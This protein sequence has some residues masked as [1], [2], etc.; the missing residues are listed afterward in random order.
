MANYALCTDKRC[1]IKGIC[2]RSTTNATV[3]KGQEYIK[4]NS[5]TYK[6]AYSLFFPITLD[7]A[8]AMGMVA[9]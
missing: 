7:S 9:P 6:K 4:P 3:E 8:R 2:V 5:C 1:P